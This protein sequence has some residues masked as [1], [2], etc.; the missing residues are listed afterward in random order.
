MWQAMTSVL[1]FGR[2]RVTHASAKLR[3]ALTGVCSASCLQG[4]AVPGSSPPSSV[5]AMTR[6]LFPAL[7]S[8]RMS[9]GGASG[10]AY[11]T[12]RRV[13]PYKTQQ[14]AMACCPVDRSGSLTRSSRTTRQGW[15]GETSTPSSR[16]SSFWARK[17]SLA[18]HALTGLLSWNILSSAFPT[19]QDRRCYFSEDPCRPTHNAYRL[20]RIGTYPRRQPCVRDPPSP[21]SSRGRRLRRPPHPPPQ[22]M[23]LHPRRY[24]LGRGGPRALCAGPITQRYRRCC[25]LYVAQRLHVDHKLTPCLL[26]SDVLS[27]RRSQRSHGDCPPRYSTLS[28]TR[29]WTITDLITAR[30][31]VWIIP[32]FQVRQAVSSDSWTPI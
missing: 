19:P 20:R 14:S 17:S 9:L 23:P 5:T 22:R 2:R 10:G 26:C 27:A 21:H 31:Q 25:V 28:L 29:M 15:F 3:L 13:V 24:Q 8:P 12:N 16:A 6:V 4:L 1:G 7:R 30:E 11:S 18:P 32:G